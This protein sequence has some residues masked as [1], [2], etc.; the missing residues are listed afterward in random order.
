[1]EEKEQK[2][3]SILDKLKGKKE[4]NPILKLK[5]DFKDPENMF[6]VTNKKGQEVL[7]VLGDIVL[8]NTGN[9][10]LKSVSELYFST[11]AVDLDKLS[12]EELIKLFKKLSG[13]E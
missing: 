6:I 1:M 7:S 8:K 12:K 3:K 2:N 11:I 10:S 5:P 4:G 9:N 13:L